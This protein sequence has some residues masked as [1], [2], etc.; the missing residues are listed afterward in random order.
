MKTLRFIGMAL[1]AVVLCVNFAA[2]SDDDD[3]PNG[4]TPSGNALKPSSLT[5]NDGSWTDYSYDAQG[6]VS[7]VEEYDETGDM[8][9]STIIEYNDNNIVATT[10]DGEHRDVCTLNSNGQI[11]RTVCTSD[12]NSYTCEYTYDGNGQL[13]GINYENG[14]SY[15]LIW[16]NG[17]LVR[18]EIDSD[19]ITCTYTSIPSSKGF[20]IYGDDILIDIFSDGNNLPL[21]ANLGYFGKAPQNML[22][23][24]T[25]TNKTS[26]NA[27]VINY[28]YELGKDGY[29]SKMSGTSQG[30]TIWGT[31]TW[32]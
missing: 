19:I 7:K 18:T 3:E 29:V 22:E 30:V 1:L 4:E 2:C 26:D 24:L 31:L 15:Q 11:V 10:N 16:E 27:T 14:E 21:L 17:N 13:T 5:W 32:E 20:I 23:T 9:N 8:Y 6:R 25:Y 12:Y 28:S